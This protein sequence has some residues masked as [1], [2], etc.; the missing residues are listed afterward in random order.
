MIQISN[1]HSV[2]AAL[3]RRPKAVK[4]ILTPSS[5]AKGHEA[6]AQA[7]KLAQAHGVPIQTS[8]NHDT[9]RRGGL[10]AE[11]EPLSPSTLE[12]ILE[13]QEGYGLW[14]AL[15]N[16][17]DPQN[18]GALF[19]TAAFFGV[20]G[21]ILTQE[22][23]APL[24]SLVY[25]IS[26]GGVEVVPFVSVVNL[27]RALE[28]MKEQGVWILGTSEHANESLYRFSWDRHRCVVLGNEESGMRRLTEETC[29]EVCAIPSFGG[30]GSLNV[31]T[32]GAILLSHFRGKASL[33]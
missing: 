29:D 6:W 31:A 8:K 2:M 19:R 20:R 10:Y 17:Q 22:R 23:S 12:G 30:V 33:F 9:Q 7:L 28:T 16:L 11:V 15:D 3:E 5:L 27:R 14:L 13:P 21:V 4:R 25:D 32:A 1:P 26:S 18:L 24:S